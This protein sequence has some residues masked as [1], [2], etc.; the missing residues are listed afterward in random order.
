MGH[1]TAIDTLVQALRAHAPGRAERESVQV[2][3]LGP[4]RRAV[5]MRY[6][7]DVE[8][9]VTGATN[10]PSSTGRRCTVQLLRLG[11]VVSEAHGIPA[12]GAGRIAKALYECLQEQVLTVTPD[13]IIATF[14]EY[15]QANRAPGLD[16]V[17]SVAQDVHGEAWLEVVD[18]ANRLGYDLAGRDGRGR[19][20]LWQA[21]RDYQDRLRAE[22]GVDPGALSR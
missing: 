9:R 14:A 1:P 18:H 11:V 21:F 15:V 20:I 10:H 12:V 4:G 8:V 5:A 3:H 16:T 19:Q 6:P 13:E 22:L 7:D 2:V 17:R